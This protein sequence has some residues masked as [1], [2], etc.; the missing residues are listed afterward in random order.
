M[1]GYI[2][3]IDFHNLE[4]ERFWSFPKSYKGNRQEETKQ[5]IL[6]ENFYGSEKKDGHYA[7][8]IKDEDGNIILQGRTKSVSGEYLDKHEWVPQ[9]NNFFEWLPKGTCL[10]GELY[11]PN[12]RG[13]RNVTTILGCL[14]NKAIE[15]QERGDKLSYYVF[16]VWAWDDNSYLNMTAKNRFD[17]LMNVGEAE[18]ENCNN[19]YVKFANYLKG[20]ELWEELGKIL[21]NGGE[22]IVITRIHSKPEPNKRTARKTLKVKMEIEQTIDA[23]L[24]GNYKKPTREYN[25]KSPETWEFYENEKTGEKVNKNKFLEM[26]KGEPWTPITKAYYY[27]WA[28]AVSFSL[29][30]DGKPVHIGYISGIPDSM[31]EGIVKNN[32]EYKNKVYELSAMEV[33]LIEGQYSLRHGK[34]IQERPDKKVEDCEWSQIAN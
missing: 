14:K 29:M 19:V 2:D 33:E 25:G 22:G 31:K 27:D 28:A 32:S 3:G 8:L 30:K 16:D 18:K 15:R 4:S 20:Q 26:T 9:L 10:L 7:R 34:I 23:F 13:S 17:V 6:S 11:F 12:K 5:M 1:F 24:D 21:S